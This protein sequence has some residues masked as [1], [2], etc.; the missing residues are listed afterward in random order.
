MS[1]VILTQEFQHV[2]QSG[3]HVMEGTNSRCLSRCS[4]NSL[5]D[6]PPLPMSLVSLGCNQIM[7]LSMPPLPD[8]LTELSCELNSI[9]VL[10]NLPPSLVSL[11]C[12]RNSLQSVL[13]LPPNLTHLDCTENQLLQLPEACLRA[14]S[15][16]LNVIPDSRCNIR[17]SP[18]PAPNGLSELQPQQA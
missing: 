9:A 11:N 15:R 3:N 4:M 16:P 6:L 10:P 8:G 17:P 7:L 2:W 5:K 12:R 18:A 14:C 1:M 13:T